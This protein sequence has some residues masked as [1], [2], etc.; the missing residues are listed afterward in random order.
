[1]NPL[2]YA[3]R[4][5]ST[6]LLSSKFVYQQASKLPK[7]S[8]VTAGILAKNRGAVLGVGALISSFGSKPTFLKRK[9]SRSQSFRLE[10]IRVTFTGQRIP[11]AL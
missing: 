11:H 6:K 8:K 1:M 2:E 5:Q 4:K 9:V 7:I 10:Q 3:Y